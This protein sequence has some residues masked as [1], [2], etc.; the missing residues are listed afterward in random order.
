MV[1]M[2]GEWLGTASLLVCFLVACDSRSATN[3]SKSDGYDT[4]LLEEAG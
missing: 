2:E 4:K 1:I 3:A